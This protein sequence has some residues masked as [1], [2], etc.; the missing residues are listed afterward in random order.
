M[1]DTI[2]PPVAPSAPASTTA[3]AA[4][5]PA[6]VPTPAPAALKPG[7]TRMSQSLGKLRESL[8]DATVDGKPIEPTPEPNRPGAVEPAK[9]DPVAKEPAKPDPAKPVAEGKPPTTPDAKPSDVP[10]DPKTGKPPGSWQ[11]KERAE[12]L[13]KVWESRALDAETKLARLGD[14]EAVT[15]RLQ[16]AEERAKKLD[17]EI[18][19]IDYSK[20]SE[21]VEKYQKPYLEQWAKVERDITQ[22]TVTD[23]EGNV[24]KA[25]VQDFLAIANM[26]AGDGDAAAE[27]WFG[28]SAQR[29]LRHVDKMRDLSESQQ[30]ALE[31]ARKN[32]SERQTQQT[33]AVKTAR[34]ESYRFLQESIEEDEERHDF[35]KPKEEDDEWNGALTKSKTFVEEAINSRPSDP[36]LTSEQ[37][38]EMV[39]KKAALRGRAIGYTMRG[40][41]L[42]RANATIAN[43]QAELAKIKE[44]QPGPGNGSHTSSGVLITDPMDRSK[45]RLRQMYEQS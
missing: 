26:P 41:E 39:R 36:K 17:E 12:K 5:S 40:V 14:P 31:D 27:A 34:E 7:E 13:A 29:V 45:A 28:K 42:K 6:P 18:K 30:K 8:K 11:L 3:P 37:R 1:P 15:K 4:P 33:E 32:G 19:Y 23:N 25:T 9:P 24:R 21:F 35:L 2:A 16:D 44:T 20:S 22:L 38:K 43:L 10:L